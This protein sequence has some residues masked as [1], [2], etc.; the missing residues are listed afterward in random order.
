MNNFFQDTENLHILSFLQNYRNAKIF[1]LADEEMLNYYPKYWSSLLPS[2]YV[3]I[4]PQKSNEKEKS[5]HSVEKITSYMIEHQIDKYDLMINWGGGMICD[6]GGFVATTYKR[7]IKFINYPTTLLAM[8][9]AAIGGK[10]GINLN[11]IKNVIGTFQSPERLFIN[12]SFLNTL[13]QEECLNGFGEMVKYALVRDVV[14]WEEIKKLT[15]FDIHTLKEDWIK[16]CIDIK[17]SIV[18]KDFY[19]QNIRRIL[20]F[21]H[22]IGHALEAYGSMQGKAI[23]HGHAVA[24][25]V[26]CESYISHIHGFITIDKANEIKNV[27]LKFFALPYFNSDDFE[28]LYA[29]AEYDKK[30]RGQD[31]NVSLLKT[32][33]SAIPNQSVTKDEILKSLEF[34]FRNPDQ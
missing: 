9:D 3:M 34:M 27:I 1:I 7:G 4:Y 5:F 10:N 26:C 33:G 17:T 12:P 25:G 14:L 31:I 13:P 6:L 19:D 18:N 23:A 20:N 22:T 16:R 24:L 28:H 30:N 29:L 8:I 2:H 32:I 21:G 15:T 11:V